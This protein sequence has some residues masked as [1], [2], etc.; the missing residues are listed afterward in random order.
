MIP[1]RRWF[2]RVE[3]PEVSHM[4][5]VSILKYPEGALTPVILTGVVLP[6]DKPMND[7]R[8]SDF[9]L[10]CSSGSEYF[11]VA[12]SHWRQEL[13]HYRWEEVKIKGLL[14]AAHMTL[15][16]Q[17]VFPKG[18]SG[19]RKEAIDLATWRGRDL[20]KK[21]TKNVTELVLVPAAVIAVMS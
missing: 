16:P 13:S 2:K 14:N 20:V 15:V 4:K 10:V 6:W 3:V 11:I 19:E 18:P 12:D 5:T 1:K 17:R 21:L 7:G 8:T 9:K